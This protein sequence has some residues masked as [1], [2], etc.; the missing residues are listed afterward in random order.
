MV[1]KVHFLF[2]SKLWK[3]SWSVTY[4]FYHKKRKS[5][6]ILRWFAKAFHD[7]TVRKS[8]Y[9]NYDERYTSS[10]TSGVFF[11][12]NKELLKK[13]KR[14]KKK[15]VNKWDAKTRH[16]S[17]KKGSKF[18]FQKIKLSSVLKP[19]NNS[20]FWC[21][22]K[23]FKWTLQYEE[24]K[25]STCILLWMS[26]ITINKYQFCTKRKYLTEKISSDNNKYVYQWW[27]HINVWGLCPFNKL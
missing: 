22:Y 26:C 3:T 17:N 12:H 8:S 23:S 13:K 24:Q 25:R 20:V 19:D 27:V 6:Q 21:I 15:K 4:Y 1:P 11:L 2:S 10:W 14:K 5:L 16:G 7:F 18:L 9:E